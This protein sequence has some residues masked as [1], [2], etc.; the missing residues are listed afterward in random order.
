MVDDVLIGGAALRERVQL[1][2]V[3]HVAPQRPQ[4]RRD[5]E[6]HEVLSGHADVLQTRHQLTVKA[7]HCIA[8]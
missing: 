4:R 1:V 8:C 7:A 5:L 6:V 2:H 3:V